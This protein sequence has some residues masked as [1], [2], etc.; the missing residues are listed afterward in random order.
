MYLKEEYCEWEDSKSWSKYNIDIWAGGIKI[1][2]YKIE[3]TVKNIV[4]HTWKLLL[5]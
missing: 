3:T 4:L 1:S 2:L 5:A